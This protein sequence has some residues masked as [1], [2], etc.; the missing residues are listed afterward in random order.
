MRCR[1]SA[2]A[3]AS[4]SFWARWSIHSVSY[5]ITVT[6]HTLYSSMEITRRDHPVLFHELLPF[7]IPGVSEYFSIHSSTCPSSPDLLR[8]RLRGEDP[9]HPDS[10]SKS[11]VNC[12]ARDFTAHLFTASNREHGVA[13]SPNRPSPSAHEGIIAI[14]VSSVVQIIDALLVQSVDAILSMRYLIIK[15]ADCFD[16]LDILVNWYYFYLV[17][18]MFFLLDDSS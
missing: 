14:S 13:L 3:R 1:Q 18:L 8:Q 9:L 5:H 6:P 16:V 12:L 11:H 7:N 2:S 15:T 10:P 4:Y 17:S